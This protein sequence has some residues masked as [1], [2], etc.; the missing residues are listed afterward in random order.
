VPPARVRG[1]FPAPRGPVLP[2][3]GGMPLPA[4]LVALVESAPLAYLTTLNRDGSPQVTGIWIGVDGEHLVSAHMGH[5]QKVRNLERNPAAVLAF[6]PP[7]VPGV[8]LAEH[9][10]LHCTATVERGGA[11]ALLTRLGRRYVAPDFTFPGE[12]SPEA[13][14]IVRYRVDR[15]AGVGPWVA[16]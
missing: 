5:N 14:Y 6:G 15:V 8:F 12:A 13:G 11:H 4:P 16:G 3:L 2:R 10:V 1:D 7:L 9:A